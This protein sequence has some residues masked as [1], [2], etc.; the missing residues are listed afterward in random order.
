MGR[1]RE[2]RP[3]LALSD[4]FD[5]SSW[6]FS[7]LVARQETGEAFYGEAVHPPAKRIR[8]CP[9][10]AALAFAIAHQH[11]G[12]LLTQSLAQLVR[13]ACQTIYN[14]SLACRCTASL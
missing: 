1:K 10:Q 14:C 7:H 6:H 9:V 11:S 3:E 5:I 4:K 2:Q 13:A 12:A 8:R